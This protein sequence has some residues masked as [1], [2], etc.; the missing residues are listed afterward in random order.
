M[1]SSPNFD[2]NNY[3]VITDSFLLQDVDTDTATIYQQLK[4]ENDAKPADEQLTDEELQE[5][6]Q[7]QAKGIARETQ[8][9]TVPSPSPT[10]PVPPS[11]LWCWLPPWRKGHF[12]ERHL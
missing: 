5:Q 1:A 10:S 4:A 8:W 6:A 2:P 12:G 11:R 3:S 9:K 7:S